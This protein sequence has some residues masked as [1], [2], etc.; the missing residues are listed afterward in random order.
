MHDFDYQK[1]SSLREAI[2]AISNPE[3]PSVLMAGGTDLLIKLKEGIIRPTRVI[4]LKGVRDL[5]GIAL[6]EKDLSVGALTSI[7]SLETS[8]TVREKAPLLAQ[9]A[10][11]LG[12]VQVRTRAT[13]GG[14]LCNAAPSA[15]TAPALLAL[16]AKAEIQGE[17]GT[18]LIDL[19]DFFSGPGAC[20]LGRGEILTSLKIPFRGN[21]TGAVYYKLSGRRAMDIAL[22]GVA[23][24]LELEKDGRIRRARIGLGAVAPTPV[25][26]FAA[27]KILEGRAFDAEAVEEAAGAAVEACRPISDLRAGAEYRREMV[28]SLCRRG[29]SA[30]Y[31]Q[32]QSRGKG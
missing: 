22:V 9:A 5:D 7:R 13:V 20:R 29:L 2:E 3:G 28:G 6:S 30:A 12:S 27:E 14:N 23:V 4:D 24:L 25:R 21:P 11:V 8:P 32:A 10:A 31:R 26:A 1:V 19:S 15:D 16:D 18:R 17:S